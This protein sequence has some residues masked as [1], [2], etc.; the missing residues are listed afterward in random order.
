M[1]RV[2]TVILV[3]LLLVSVVLTGCSAPAEKKE[4]AAEE[5]KPDK[6]TL[7]I[8]LPL[9][10]TF[11][12]VAK[13]QEQGALVAAEDVN[14][15]GGLSMP[16]GKVRVI[17]LT[18]DDQ[19][20]LDIGVRR[21]EYLRDAGANA[22]VG[23]TWAPLALAINEKT[24]QNPVLYFPVCV[25]P[26]E[27]LKKGTLSPTTWVTAYTPWS[28][29]Y[30]AASAAINELGKKRIF[31]LARSD[32]WGWDIGAGVKAAAEKYG[33]EIVGTDEVPLGTTDFLAVLKKVRAAK[34]D[35][36]ISAQFGA[37]AIALLKQAYDQGLYKEMTIFNAFITNVVAQGLPPGALEGL[38]A[39]HFYYW[40][41]TGFPDQEVAKA[42]VEYTERFKEQWGTP[43]DAYATIAY[44]ATRQ[45][46]DAVQAA[47]TFD[48]VKVA[49][50]IQQ[51]PEFSTVKGPAKWREDHSPIYKY[52]AF[53]VKGKAA[54]EKKHEWDLFTVVSAQGGESVLPPLE[55]LGYK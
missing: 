10:G 49:E 15:A 18:M 48:P 30:M 37:D 4:Q 47:G 27:S 3:S 12:A 42:S 7:G 46:L 9:T 51:N 53:L 45:I 36:F 50:Y 1:R 28:V 43:P 54:S 25:T 31:F 32:S 34:P 39:M 38:Y 44:I 35:V 21:F 14:R 40:D 24:R 20:N 5:P 26:V 11:A 22:V 2:L 13:T 23:Q 19:A 52:A 8:L 6:F 16:W 17:P 29:G 33:A 55:M 41:L